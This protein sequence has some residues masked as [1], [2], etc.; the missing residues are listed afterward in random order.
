MSK[1][2]T[3]MKTHTALHLQMKENITEYF[4]D[5]TT[6]DEYA[7]K[8]HPDPHPKRKLREQCWKEIN[9]DG[10]RT[11]RLWLK[12][13]LI[14]FKKNEWAKPGKKPR[15]IGDLGVGASLQ[16]FK[17]T[18]F[19]KKAMAAEP[20]VYK[21]FTIEFCAKPEPSVLVEVFQKLLNPPGKGYL[22]YFSDDSCVSYRHNGKVHIYNMDISSCDA[23]HGPEIFNSLIAITPDVA[24]DD[25]RV[26]VEQCCL[27]IRIVSVEDKN[28]FVKLKAKHPKLYSGSTITTILNNFANINIGFAIAESFQYDQAPDPISAAEQVG[29]IVSL[30]KCETM[31]DIQFLKHSPV[32]DDSGNMRA[33]M[34]FGVLLRASGTCNG[35]LPGRGSI[36]LRARE[37][38]G[39]LIQGMYPRTRAPILSTMLSHTH[40]PRDSISTC[41]NRE[42][43]YKVCQPTEEAAYR[44][45][46]QEIWKRYRLSPA[47]AA[48]LEE[49]LDNGYETSWIC[50]ASQ[51]ILEKDYG[52]TGL[53]W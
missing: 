41:V 48:T 27:P 50:P 10:V 7:L 32:F 29:Y 45:T 23:S 51:A 31:Y 16:G 3:F 20:I 43:R 12:S 28:N 39:A 53:T 25:M 42:L 22:V 49:G 37:F 33:L 14:K 34:N 26:L 4:F 2:A 24:Q 40:S 18:A 19:I 13:V 17:T 36:E 6:A 47:D 46:N 15:C 30:E 9:E 44:I 8:H 21:D 11:N 5:Y 52:L 38:Q 1:Q 35:D